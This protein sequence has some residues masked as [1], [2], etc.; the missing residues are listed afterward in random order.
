MFITLTCDHGDIPWA[1]RVTAKRL[2]YLMQVSL[3]A[4]PQGRQSVQFTILKWTYY[5][6]IP[7]QQVLAI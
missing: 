7:F 4:V 5:I 3:E 1:E 6:N 2:K